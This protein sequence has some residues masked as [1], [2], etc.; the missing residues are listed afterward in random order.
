MLVIEAALGL[1]A[2]AERLRPRSARV[3]TIVLPALLVSGRAYST[4]ALPESHGFANVEQWATVGRWLGQH[5]PGETIATIPVGA[6]A[7]HS[8]LR[9][10]DL[11]GITNREVVREG[12]RVPEA[13]LRR[14]WLGH[15]RHATAWILQRAPDLIVT[16]KAR[17]EPWRDLDE[18]KA[19]FYADWRLLQ[20]IKAGR[21]PYRL[22]DAEVA[23]GL[24]WLM[25]QRD[26][27]R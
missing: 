9:T 19:G 26:D 3:A 12:E 15:E 6:M 2:V 20:E 16:T 23:P 7:Y 22:Y 11:V 4:H 8:G 13:M 25:F 1:A 14:H 17:A 24:H 21:A 18:A 5:H 10:L 27:T